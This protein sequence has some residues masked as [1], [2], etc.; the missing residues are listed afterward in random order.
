MLWLRLDHYQNQKLDTETQDVVS[1][2]HPEAEAGAAVRH[3]HAATI[4]NF[5]QVRSEPLSLIGQPKYPE[6]TTEGDDL[7]TEYATT[8]MNSQL[9]FDQVE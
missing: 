7:E 1:V 8:G 6:Q 4:G 5:T 2:N 3:T 9:L